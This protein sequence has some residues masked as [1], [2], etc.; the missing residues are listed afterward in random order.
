MIKKNIGYC[1]LKK[2]TDSIKANSLLCRVG[3]GEKDY[4]ASGVIAASNGG[5]YYTTLPIWNIGKYIATI[6]PPITTPSTA[7]IIGSSKLVKPS[8]MS[9]TSAS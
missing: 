1:W 3:Y 8:T 6:K 9:S 5:K 7:M 4:V 2:I